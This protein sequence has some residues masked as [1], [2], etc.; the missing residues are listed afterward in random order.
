MERMDPV[1]ALTLHVIFLVMGISGNLFILTVHFMDWLK[2]RSINACALILN[3][4]AFSNISFQGTIVANEFSFYLFN[5]FFS[6]DW[7]IKSFV[8][9]IV[10]LSFSSLWFSTC[11]CFYYCV[12]IVN[13][14]IAFF[15][16]LKTKLPVMVP[17]M[18]VASFILSWISGIT[19]YWDL[20]TEQ[21]TSTAVNVS[22]NKTFLAG[23]SFRSSCSCLFPIYIFLSSMAFTVIFCTAMAIVTSLC[24]HMRRMKKNNDGF[25]NTSLVSHLS[26][27]KTVTTLLFV[28]MTFYGALNIMFNMAT[29]AGSLLFSLCIIVISSFPSVNVLILIMGNRHLK[30]ILKQVLGAKANSSS[31]GK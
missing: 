11:L 12:K 1:L 27:A 7:V 20:Q 18:L 6:Q 16:K 30:D 28:Y 8:T 13:L 4:I 25:G 26:A 17:W 31:E 9:I 14:N 15:Q 24:K 5:A 3:C 22:R 23:Y 29:T 10:C 19:S 21:L 2:T